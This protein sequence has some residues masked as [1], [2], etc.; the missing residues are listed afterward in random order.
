MMTQNKFVCRQCKLVLYHNLIS[1]MYDR[2]VNFYTFEN[3]ISY[4]MTA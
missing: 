3:Y 1:S 2:F 4:S